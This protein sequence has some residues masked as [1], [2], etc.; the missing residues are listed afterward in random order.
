MFRHQGN[1]R[2]LK[3]N[4]ALAS[5]LAFVA[6]LVNVAGFLSVQ[7]LTTNVTGHFAYFV[8]EIF[9][10]QFLNGFIYFLYIFFFFLGSFISNFLVEIISKNSK[11]NVFIVPV[12]FESLILLII[13]SNTDFSEE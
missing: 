9:K 11:N 3:H 13:F 12:I 8:A 5:L 7:K 6:G 2:T 10:L 1:N 4:M